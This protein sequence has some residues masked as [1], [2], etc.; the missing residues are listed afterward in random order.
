VRRRL[1]AGAALLALGAAAACT[2][3]TSDGGTVVALAVDSL[4][5]TTIVVGDTLRGATLAPVPVRVR[6]FTGAGDT[7]PDAEIITIP[8]DDAT[9]RA[10][11]ITPERFVIARDTATAARFVFRAGAIQTSILTVQVVDSVPRLARADTLRDSLVYDAADTTARIA[12]VQALLRRGTAPAGALVG[13]GGFRVA[14]DVERLPTLLD[15]VAFFGPGGRRIAGAIT[16][17]DGLARVRVRG[18]GRPGTTGRDTL[19][20]RARLVA[21]G[22]AVPGSPLRLPVLIRSVTSAP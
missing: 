16:G 22:V 11:T 5:A 4:P 18:F 1:L 15:S 2:E 17:T 8:L 12:E 7:I 21:R 20:L 6:A 3:V 9:R 13:A 14:F 19:V 10:L